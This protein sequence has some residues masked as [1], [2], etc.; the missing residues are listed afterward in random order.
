MLL[1]KFFVFQLFLFIVFPFAVF[2]QTS[3]EEII[4][5]MTEPHEGRPHGVPS[6]YDWA[7]KPRRGAETPPETWN[8]AIAWGQLYEW[9]EGN[10]ATN[11][12]VQIRDL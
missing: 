2:S 4:S 10:P 8:A 11:T 9:I 6:N 3:L 1:K 7:L 5:D 12:R